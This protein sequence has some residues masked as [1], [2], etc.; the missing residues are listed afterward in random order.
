MPKVS[1]NSITSGYGTVDALNANFDAIEAAFDNTVSRD[2][3]TPNQMVSNLDMN[4]FSIL[5]QGNPITV[6]GFNWEGQWLTAT[7]Y[8]VGDAIQQSGSAYIC[9]IAHT[10]GTFATDLAALRWQLVAQANLPTQTGNSGKYLTTNGTSASWGNVEYTPLGTGAIQRTVTGKLQESVSVKDFGAVGDGVTNNSAA[11]IAARTA[12]AGKRIYVPSGHYKLNQALTS[13]EDLILEGDGNS[14]ILDFTGTITG[15]SYALEAT[16]TATQIQGLGASATV[17]TYTVTFAS[18][19]SLAIG[20]VFVI[21]NPTGSSWSAF[22]ANYYAGEWCEVESISGNVVTVRNQLYD[23][24]TAV[25][26]NVYRIA[27]PKVSLKNFEIRGTTVE[28]L[29]CPRLCI[30]PFIENVKGTH[31]NDSVVY[32]DRCFKPTVVNSDMSNVGDGG[33]DYGIVIGSSQHARI[34]NGNIYARRHAVST[35]GA[36][37]ICDVPVRDA[38]IIGATLKNDTASGVFCAD[39]HGNTEDSS[40]IDCTIYGGAAWQGKDIEYVNCT[41]TADTGGRVIYSAEIKGGKFALKGC[42]LITHVDPS[43]T[44]RG[45]VDIGG[46]NSPV[47]SNTTLPATFIIENCELY[48]RNLSAITSFVTFKNS[49]ATVKTNFV[50]DGV[51]ANINTLGQILYTA[52]SAG[53]ANSDFVIIDRIAGFPT[54]VFLHNSLSNAY[55]N[56]PHRCQKQTGSLSITATSGTNNTIASYSNFKYVYPRTPVAF[57]STAGSFTVFNGNKPILANIFDLDTARIRPVISTGDA[58][59]WTATNTVLFGWS[60]EI[61][62]I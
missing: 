37:N 2:G 62:D 56:F 26:V 6:E 36:A 48:A 19:P 58:V 50:I 31:A 61:N 55:V 53:T 11:F 59:N 57:V 42:K 7:A 33:D 14:T 43:A 15:G 47:T 21:Y 32:L 45:I 12:A 24:Y 54:G 27:S 52:N 35:G 40:Y 17:G 44:S 1:L 51:K 28:G 4:G 5:N 20:D 39:F 13:S 3:D 46:N 41:I 8:Q 30:A 18:A 60:V 9:V 23:T 10:S 34:I 38:R 49:G 25:S 22:R 16:G 29:I